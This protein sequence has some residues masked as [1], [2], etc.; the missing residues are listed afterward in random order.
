VLSLFHPKFG[1]ENFKTTIL[2]FSGP[3]RITG[4]PKQHH[5]TQRSDIRHGN[6]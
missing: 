5:V 3:T 4:Y 6:K 2:A 1:A